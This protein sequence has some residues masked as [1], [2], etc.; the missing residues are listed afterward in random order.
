MGKYEISKFLWIF[1]G[2]ALLYPSILG[3]FSIIDADL[4]LKT[5]AATVAQIASA[6]IC[7]LYAP[8]SHKSVGLSFILATTL[9]FTLSVLVKFSQDSTH[10]LTYYASFALF[11]III[12]SALEAMRRGDKSTPRFP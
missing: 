3:I 5:M 12:W 6:A 7:F 9:G 10:S 4:P 8:F 11:G 2:L 1:S